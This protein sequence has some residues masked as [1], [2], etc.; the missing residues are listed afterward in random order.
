[1]IASTENKGFHLTFTNGYTISVQ[2]GSGNYCNNRNRKDTPAYIYSCKNAEVAY[3]KNEDK[4]DFIIDSYCDA[5]QV[6][7]LIDHVS[8]L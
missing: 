1:M 3:W 6:A 7:E 5:N 8:K 2:F 4:S